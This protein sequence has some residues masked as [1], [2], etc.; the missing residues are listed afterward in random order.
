MERATLKCS[1]ALG[2]ELMA[3]IDEPRFFGAVLL[4]AHWD[5]IVIRLVGL[6]E[7]CC[8]RVRDRS[9]VAHPVQRIA[10]IQPVAKRDPDFFPNRHA[11]QDSCHITDLTLQIYTITYHATARSG[12]AMP[13][14]RR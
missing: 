2:N 9:L 7:V 12:N 14:V 13:C 10:G 8:V 11:L 6:A 4:R 3:A 1:K 5:L